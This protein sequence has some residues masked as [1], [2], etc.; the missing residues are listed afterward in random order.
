METLD[1]F[2]WNSATRFGWWNSRRRPSLS[3]CQSDTDPNRK[4]EF[5][6]VCV[7]VCVCVCLCFL[8]LLLLF[9][10]DF[11]MLPCE[12]D[13]GTME[14]KTAPWICRRTSHNE[15]PRLAQGTADQKETAI[16]VGKKKAPNWAESA[17]RNDG[18]TRRSIDESARHGWKK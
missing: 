5:L 1:R 16:K 2:D 11:W 18:G 6:C 10:W 14:R 13:R 12:T 15:E 7:C 4:P 17:S 3:R 8:E 9:L